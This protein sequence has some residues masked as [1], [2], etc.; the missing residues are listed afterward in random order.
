MNRISAR[1]SMAVV[2]AT[3]GI[4][5]AGCGGSSSTS[6]STNAAAAGGGPGRFASN[7]KVVACLKQHGVT[8][9]SGRP[10]GAGGPPNGTNPGGQPP[11]GAPGRAGGSAQFQKFR[12]ALKACGV[13]PPQRGAG[14]QGA[15]GAAPAQGTATQTQTS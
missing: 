5:V 11:A 12:A 8:P 3:L 10:G 7:P 15:P 13:T 2:V 4:A 6:S 9:P 1:S 14:G